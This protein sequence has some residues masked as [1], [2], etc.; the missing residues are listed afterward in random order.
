MDVCI[1]TNTISTR[2][3]LVKEIRC[4]ICTCI[5]VT[6]WTL[7]ACTSTWVTITSNI[8]LYSKTTAC[9]LTISSWQVEKSISCLTLPCHHIKYIRLTPTK[10]SSIGQCPW[11]LKFNTKISLSIDSFIDKLPLILKSTIGILTL[12]SYNS[13]NE[14]IYKGNWDSQE[15]SISIIEPSLKDYKIFLW[16]LNIIWVE[17]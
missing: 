6:L 11:P 16:R 3:H 14:I 10:S 8:V 1:Y 15:A 17:N 7:I 13:H 12:K 4:T 5:M 2:V 9:S